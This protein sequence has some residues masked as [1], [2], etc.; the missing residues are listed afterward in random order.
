LISFGVGGLLFREQNRAR[1][2]VGLAIILAGVLII[3]FA[4]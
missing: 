1:K 4:V 3:V 2:A